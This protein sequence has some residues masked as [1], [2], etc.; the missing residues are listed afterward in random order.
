[1]RIMNGRS[2]LLF[3][4]MFFLLHSCVAQNKQTLEEE[5]EKIMYKYEAVGVSAVVVKDNKICYTHTFGYNPDYNDTT[6][7]KPIPKNG[8]YVI[9]SI[10]KTFVSTAIM[11]LVEKKKLKLDEDINKYL[12][13]IVRNPKYPDVPITIRML[14]CHRSSLNDSQYGWT[15]SQIDPATGKDWKGCYNDYAPGDDYKYCNLGYSLLGAIIENVTGERFYNYVETHITKPLGLYANYNLTKIDSNMLVRALSYNQKKRTFWIDN[16]IYNY[17]YYEDK[18]QDYQL[19]YSVAYFSP[20][21]GV[22]ISA[23]DLAKYM[24]MHMNEGKY[25]GKRIISRKSEMEM[26]KTQMGNIN[27]GLGFSQYKGRVK[28]EALDGMVGCAHGVHSSMLFNRKE[29]YGF[30]VI[31]NGCTSKAKDGQNMNTEIIQQLYKFIVKK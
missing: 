3:G 5:I 29:K 27:Y 1:M 20:T 30:V 18:L 11:Q 22:K 21:G 7:R 24:M 17:P 14:L 13:F 10:S 15:L 9:A 31:C 26:Q 28:G 4:I 25:G 23:T 16:S 12:T 8:I 19:G 6:L 2:C